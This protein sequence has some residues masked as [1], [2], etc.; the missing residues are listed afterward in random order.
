MKK[1]IIRLI[2][3]ALIIVILYCL[4][5]IG[6]YYY[7]R[8]KADKEFDEYKDIVADTA[9]GSHKKS[10]SG[11]KNGSEDGAITDGINAQ[12]TDLLHLIDQKSFKDHK[13]E[14]D[15]VAKDS[16][17]K[18]RSKNED[19]YSYINIPELDVSYPVVHKDNEYYLRRN[20]KKEYSIAGTIF[21]EEKN[22][23]D[24]TDMNTVIYGHNMSNA[25]TKSAEMFEPILK[26][27]DQGFVDSRQ[28]HYIELYTKNGVNRYKV[29]SA[30]YSNAYYDYRT[31]NMDKSEWK[32]YLDKIVKDSE[33]N[34]KD[35]NL[36]KDSRIIT[37][38]TCDNVTDDGR[39]AVH[40][41]LVN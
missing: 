30:Y 28:D 27:A 3:F 13:A 18:F 31:L 29:F 37:L 21:M 16:L 38:S 4:Y 6:S 33:T 14:Y 12:G 10:S 5:D 7:G 15:Q 11:S 32:S 26:Y 17:I 25:I 35:V 22:N 20:L 23:P 1:N 24:L 34:F 39:F 9:L 41:V 36:N 2:Q 19:I 8:Y 40:A